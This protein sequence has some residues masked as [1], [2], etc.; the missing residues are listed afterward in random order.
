VKREQ[1]E[2]LHRA[3]VGAT[4][5]RMLREIADALQ[6]ITAQIALLVLLEDMH[7]ADC[8]TVDLSRCW[9]AVEN[10]PN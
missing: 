2:E 10:H 1:R 7:W 9:A 3:I 5:E 6:T 4:R 8:S